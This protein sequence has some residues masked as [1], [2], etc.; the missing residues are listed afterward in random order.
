MS[1]RGISFWSKSKCN[2]AAAFALGPRIF[3]KFASHQ[4]LWLQRNAWE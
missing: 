2:A 3:A 1:V 4:G